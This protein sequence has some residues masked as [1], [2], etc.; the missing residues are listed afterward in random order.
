M[1]EEQ[2]KTYADRGLSREEVE[3]IT[4]LS[5]SALYRRMSEGTFPRPV[6]LGSKR[7]VAW[8]ESEVLAWLRA[9]PRSQGRVSA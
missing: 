9:Q 2:Q 1:I 5:T 7:R 3:H 4:T 8:I 6:A